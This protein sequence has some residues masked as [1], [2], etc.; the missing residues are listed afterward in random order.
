MRETVTI[1]C[2]DVFHF[3]FCSIKSLVLLLTIQQN[4]QHKSLLLWP[5]FV[6]LTIL[7]ACMEIYMISR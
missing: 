2:V 3:Y 6:I 5:R 1:F 4:H 7:S